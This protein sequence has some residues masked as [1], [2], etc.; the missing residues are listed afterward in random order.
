MELPE[1]LLRKA[2]AGLSRGSILFW[3]GYPFRDGTVGD[4]MVLLLS[5]CVEDRC[6][7]VV[8]PTSQ[9]QHYVTGRREMVDTVCFP[10]G[11]SSWFEKDTVVDL[12]RY[13][14]VSVEDLAPHFV[15]GAA[16]K[17]GELD[18]TDMTK[19]IEVVKNAETLSPRVQKHILGD[20]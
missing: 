7:V 17:I 8:L 12:K 13:D 2:A 18:G 19:I 16:K 3:R 10:K 1:E 4:K 15:S 9:I 11:E 20:D 14:E 5:E 6:Y